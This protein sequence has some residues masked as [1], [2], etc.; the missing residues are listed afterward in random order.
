MATAAWAASSRSMP[1]VPS[2]TDWMGSCQITI[3]TPE[4]WPSRSTGSK[5]AERAEVA[6]TSGCASAGCERASVTK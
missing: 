1:A 2:G 3:S 5:S 6:S 4:T